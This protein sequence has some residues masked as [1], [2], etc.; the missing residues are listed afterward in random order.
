MLRTDSCWRKLGLKSSLIDG[1]VSVGSSSVCVLLCLMPWVLASVPAVFSSSDWHYALIFTYW[2]DLDYRLFRRRFENRQRKESS[3][4]IDEKVINV[5]TVLTNSFNSEFA[6][7]TEI[8]AQKSDVGVDSNVKD[9][10]YTDTLVALIRRSPC[11]AVVLK[12]PAKGLQ[13]LP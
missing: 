11:V 12:Q 9:S 1:G 13:V 6:T 10:P 3:K 4:N 5:F 8:L 7:G 2:V